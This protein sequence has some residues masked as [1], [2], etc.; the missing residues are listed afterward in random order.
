MPHLPF[1]REWLRKEHGCTRQDMPIAGAL[2]K[3]VWL[4][5]LQHAGASQERFATPSLL[6]IGGVC[7][8]RRA[9]LYEVAG[10]A[11]CRGCP[12]GHPS[13]R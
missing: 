9:Q 11:R 5:A 4:H 6:L 2:Q 8:P 12:V 10:H 1:T 3:P 13:G 7:A